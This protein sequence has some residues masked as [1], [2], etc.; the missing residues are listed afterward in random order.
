[1]FI[2][3]NSPRIGNLVKHQNASK[4]NDHVCLQNFLLLF[5]SLLTAPIVKNNHT[6]AGIYIILLKNAQV[7]T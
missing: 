1:M 4:Y 6:L 7:K 5:M 2:T 3:N